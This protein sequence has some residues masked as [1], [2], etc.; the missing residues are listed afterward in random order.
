MLICTVDLVFQKFV[1]SG[2]RLEQ[3]KKKW[4]ERVEQFHALQSLGEKTK[5]TP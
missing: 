4:L 5:E 3:L 2:N 1:L